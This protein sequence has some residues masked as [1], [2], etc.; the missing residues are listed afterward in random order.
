MEHKRPNLQNVLKQAMTEYENDNPEDEQ[1]SMDYDGDGLT[2]SISNLNNTNAKLH[3]A[4]KNIQE[5]LTTVSQNTIHAS[6]HV[7]KEANRRSNDNSFSAGLV[8]ENSKE[9]RKLGE[10]LKDSIEDS[11]APLMKALVMTENIGVSLDRYYDI[12]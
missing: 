3:E 2:E 5:I 1:E 8:K 12:K 9:I 4:V 6:H 11:I 7:M 10:A